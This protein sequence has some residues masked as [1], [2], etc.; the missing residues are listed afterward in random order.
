MNPTVT[1]TEFSIETFMAAWHDFTETLKGEGTRII[2]MFKSI[3]PEVENG[4]TIK[5]HLSN[6]AQKDLFVQ[7]YRQRLIKFS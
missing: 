6:A 4:N 7:N 3:Q 1:R 2:S 5:I